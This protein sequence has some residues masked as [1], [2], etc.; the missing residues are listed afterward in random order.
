MPSV[1]SLTPITLKHVRFF[2]YLEWI[3]LVIVL[4]F[5]LGQARGSQVIL[6]DREPFYTPATAT[7]F[8]G[9]SVQWYNQSMQPHTVTHDGCRQG[10]TC[11]FSS[12]H[13]HP[14]ERFTVRNLPAGTYS[15]HCEIHPFM[16]GRIQVKQAAR[17]DGVMEL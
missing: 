17:N 12:E 5:S 7:I 16:R 4:P 8:P 2:Y 10:G 15:Y 13:L 6:L 14:G 11:A 1:T 9:Q 3:M